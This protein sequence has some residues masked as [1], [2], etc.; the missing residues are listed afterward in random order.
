MSSEYKIKLRWLIIISTL[1]RCIFAFNIE[2][3]NDEVYYFTYAV[4]LDW[5]HF[6]HPPLIGLLI[7]FF[8]LNL[9]WVNEFSMRLGAIFLAAIN[10]W[11]IAK[12]AG[13]LLNERTGLIAAILYTASLYSSII[14]G[15]FIL[16][17]SIANTFWLAALGSMIV[18]VKSEDRILKDNHL[19]LLGLWVGLGCLSKVHSIFLW[20][21]FLSYILI[22]QREI[23]KNKE[24]YLGLILTAVCFLPILFWNEEYDYITWKFHSQRVSFL[25]SGIRWDFFAQTSFGQIFYNN[26]FL[27][28]LYII[29]FISLVKN[30][31]KIFDV[32]TKIIWLLLFC[33][34]PIILVTSS[35]SMFRQTLPHWSGAGFFAMMLIAACWIDRKLD[36]DN[37]IRIRRLLNFQLSFVLIIMVLAF[38]TIKW[39]PGNLFVKANINEIGKGDVTLDMTG[40]KDL[41]KQFSQLRNIDIKNGKMKESDALI[42]N[43]WYPAGHF[44][45][46]LSRPLQ[47]RMIAVGRLNDI[48][49]FA[50]MNL[51]I[52]EIK[53]KENAY[54][55]VA[56]NMFQD[57]SLLFS[58]LFEEVKLHKTLEQKRSN[59]LV[60]K[61]YIYHLYNA[62]SAIGNKHPLLYME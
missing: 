32:P 30:R 43:N 7:R 33:S 51:A 34:L 14:S 60:R 36:N 1:I 9:N 42:I 31:F 18:V 26:P 52:P 16:P 59:K 20:L 45:F 6:D 41:E 35:L 46:Y 10:T 3:G 55:I 56:S 11:L 37:I 8:T 22:F 38:A 44:Y 49:K 29:V 5:N 39:Y 13:Y 50:W 25:E 54:F 12:I 58:D 2:L 15:L 23:L 48:H 19:I 53:P 17:D 24:L 57:P 62:K 28:Y 4:Q 61:W 47:M 40:W 27:I 21:G